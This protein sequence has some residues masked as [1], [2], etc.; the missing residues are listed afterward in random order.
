MIGKHHHHHRH[1]SVFPPSE[2]LGEVWGFEELRGYLKAKPGRCVLLLDG[3]VVD[4]T[5]YLGEHVRI[6]MLMFLVVHG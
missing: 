1:Q 6:L 2:W 4:A 3:M 5:S